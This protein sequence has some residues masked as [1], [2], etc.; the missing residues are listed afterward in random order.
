MKRTNLEVSRLLIPVIK[1][2]WNYIQHGLKYSKE[3]IDQL[4]D[5]TKDCEY[6]GQYV[7]I[8]QDIITGSN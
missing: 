3:T 2:D 6:E 1:G 8:I 5:M 4:R 7:K